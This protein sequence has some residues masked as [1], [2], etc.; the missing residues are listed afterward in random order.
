MTARLEINDNLA[1]IT[2]ARPGAHNALNRELKEAF[3]QAV[4]SVAKDD[5]VRAVLL[6]AEGKNFCVGQDLAEH[7]DALRRDPSTA[8]NTVAEHYNPLIAALAG[9]EVPVVVAIPG[10][11]VGAGFG[12]ALAGDIRVAGE[13]TTFATAFTGIGLGSDSGLSHA[14]VAALGPSRA[15]GLMLLG[16]RITAAQAL[17]WGLVHKVVADAEVVD[18]AHT[19]ARQLAA[20]PTEAYREV[21]KLIAASNTGLAEALE[22]ERASQ[23]HLGQTHD[24]RAAVDAFLAKEKPVFS[25]S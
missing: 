25:G 3:L 5:A 2:L 6:T 11:C 14:L 22:R 21:K 16:E 10:A 1:I 7:V 20:G 18:T 17:E 12:I 24:H 15:A 8:M 23:Q 19:L 13:K 4:Q 9:I